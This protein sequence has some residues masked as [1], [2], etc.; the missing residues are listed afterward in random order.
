MQHPPPSL[1]ENAD[2][3]DNYKGVGMIA[4]LNGIGWQRG[5]NPLS[6]DVEDACN[7]RMDEMSSRK[8]QFAMTRRIISIR[9]RQLDV[10]DVSWIQNIQR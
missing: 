9:P 8:K 7:E 4:G 1:I 6:A 2:G 5:S 3:R 10:E